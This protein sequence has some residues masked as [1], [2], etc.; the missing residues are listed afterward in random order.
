MTVE[1]DEMNNIVLDIDN[2]VVGLGARPSDSTSDH[3]PPNAA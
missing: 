3:R 2:L 1:G